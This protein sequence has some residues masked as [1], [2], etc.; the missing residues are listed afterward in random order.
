MVDELSNTLP[1]APTNTPTRVTQ[2]TRHIMSDMALFSRH[3][4]GLPLHRY[5]VKNLYPIIDSILKQKGLEFMLIYPR[6]SGKNESVAQLLAYLLLLLSRTG[7]TIVYAAVGD[8]LG[9]GIRRLEERLDNPW[10]ANQIQKR[11]RPTG[12]AIGSCTVNFLSANP[13]AAARGETASHLLVLDEAQDLQGSHIEAVF[14][15]MRAANN[16]TALYLGTTKSTNDFLWH[17]KQELEHQTAQD[18]IRRVF[19]VTPEEVI[20]E[21]PA[22]A[23]FLQTQIAKHG[24]N[25]PIIL[26]EYYLTPVDAQGGLF[27]ERRRSMMIGDYARY[28]RPKRMGLYV[29]TLDV[30]GQDEGATDPVAQLDSPGRDY[31]VCTI[32]EVIPARNEAPGPTYAAVDVFVDQGGKHFE[33]VPGQPKLADR[34]MAYLRHWQVQHLVTDASGVGEGLTSYL[35]AKLGTSHVTGFSFA[36]RSAKAMLGSGFLSIIETGRFRY[37]SDDMD[38]HGSDGWWFWQQAINCGYE[39][40]PDGTFERDLKWGVGN[41]KKVDLPG[42]GLVLLHDDRLLSAAL[43]TQIDELSRKGELLLGHAFSAIINPF[44]P[45]NVDNVGF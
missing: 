2:A 5:Q 8:G 26:S 23:I 42:R 18:G 45:A 10:T 27:N 43:I 35:A 22:Y 39:L 28:H 13:L 30:G 17:K 16:A 21:N 36:R 15:P 4:I 31:T 20:R 41:H 25:H 32:F 40:P 34:L 37:W 38:A 19:M 24:R 3:V 6:Q 33:D 1:A 7:G 9:R 12:R 29:A 11:S 14:T 44:D